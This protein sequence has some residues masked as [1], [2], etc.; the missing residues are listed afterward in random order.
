MRSGARIAVGA[1]MLL[2]AGLVGCAGKGETKAV[3][4]Q[5]AEVAVRPMGTGIQG[6]VIGVDGK[7]VPLVSVWF[8]P[9]AKDNEPTE[10][11]S[12]STLEDGT[13][14]FDALKPGKY[15]VWTLKIYNNQ[16]LSAE[17]EVEVVA[18]KATTVQLGFGDYREISGVLSLGG[19][20]FKPADGRV[21]FVPAD[22]SRPAEA[23]L[24]EDGIYS[25]FLRPG[26]YKVGIMKAPFGLRVAGDPIEVS[27]SKKALRKNFSFPTSDLNVTLKP[28]AGETF[29]EG[30]LTAEF[31]T[32]TN[33]ET[34]R[35]QMNSPEYTI[36]GVL[37]GSYSLGV[38]TSSGLQGVSGPFEVGAGKAASVEIA[39][40]RPTDRVYYGKFKLPPGRHEYKFF[41]PADNWKDDILNP[42]KVGE[43]VLTN[44]LVSVP[45]GA[46]DGDKKRST[47][48]RVDDKT[49]ETEFWVSLPTLTKQVYV[50]GSFN[51]WRTAPEWQL[52]EVPE[53]IYT[54]SIKLPAGMHEYKVYSTDDVWWLD[55][56]N[57]Q[58]SG[59]EL[60][61]NN[62]V[63]VP[64]DGTPGPA[65]HYPRFDPKTGLTTFRVPVSTLTGEVY[66]C[67]TFNNWEKK[68][69]FKMKAE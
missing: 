24:R 16:L 15:R 59:A 32:F 1:L 28:P 29:N 57:S 64:A 50:R 11:S 44:S 38:T 30:T 7:P 4:E 17:S 12:T 33:P 34:W 45:G 56:D 60:K 54:T 26:A 6:T 10:S 55:R 8:A 63:V 49:N 48:P 21:D 27:A 66:L 67:G 35:I 2:A 39:L 18:D 62:V 13:F 58:Q 25:A 42:E 52:T 47:W 41:S 5:A 3:V 19:Q 53:K 9:A 65:D 43:G 31:A 46:V 23:F 40:Q 61:I 37:P 68:P 14:R 69:E 36:S 20:P 51:Q 22:G